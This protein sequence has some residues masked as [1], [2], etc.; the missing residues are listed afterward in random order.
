MRSRPATEADLQDVT[1]TLTA[2]FEHD[3]LWRWAFADLAGLEALWGFL[4]RSAL[5]YPW[6]RMLDG[7]AAAALW[8]PPGG[9]ELTDDEAARLQAELPEHVTSLFD[10]FERCHPHAP[11]HYYLSLLGTRPGQ[12]GSGLGM[13]LLAE[14]LE[15][16]DAEGVPTYLESSN[17]AND[18]R[19][20]QVG[21]RKVGSFST[22][23]GAHSVATMWREP[24]IG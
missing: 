20:E 13:G 12:R 10:R 24:V 5:R 4:L 1:A 8:I 21:Y 23:D 15:L 2:A 22:P 19:Y 16:F 11:P 18:A 9:T 17:P 6:V 14:C 3:P 7:A